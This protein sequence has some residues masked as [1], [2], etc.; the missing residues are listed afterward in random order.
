MVSVRP[1]ELSDIPRIA[2]IHVLSWQAAYEGILPAE[3]L[4]NLSIERRQEHWSSNFGDRQTLVVEFEGAVAGF[5][6][7]AATEDPNLGEVQSIYL[8]PRLYR[9]GLG[10]P[11]LHA[12]EQRLA[13]MGFREGVLWVFVDNRAARSFYE[14]MGWKREPR[15]ALMELGGRQL[16]EVRYHKTFA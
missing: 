1:A 10:R 13:E 5:V 15:T 6:G 2:E 7:V 4:A 16:T 12:G 8:D 9:R 11:L 14:A 3:F